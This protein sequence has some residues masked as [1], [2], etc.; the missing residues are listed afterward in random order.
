MKDKYLIITKQD[1]DL[2]WIEDIIR[3]WNLNEYIQ[4]YAFK[5]E[6][7]SKMS[8]PLKVVKILQ[9]PNTVSF[10]VDY[11]KGGEPVCEHS[12]EIENVGTTDNFQHDNIWWT[13][14]GDEFRNRCTEKEIKGIEWVREAGLK[15]VEK[16]LLPKELIDLTEQEF[17]D[18]KDSGMLWEFFPESPD[19]WKDIKKECI[20]NV[21]LTGRCF[22]CGEQT[23]LTNWKTSGLYKQDW[24]EVAG[25]NVGKLED[26]VCIYCG[27]NDE[28]CNCI[29]CANCGK[30]NEECNC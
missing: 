6:H 7:D 1:Y 20:H 15:K 27:K 23:D 29:I 9:R 10:Y 12:F 4:Y 16:K 18:L 3:P 26:E 25:P 8:V 5:L 21:D 13:S 28:E 14:T 22:K 17:N 30:L 2:F 11:G 19:F 24:K